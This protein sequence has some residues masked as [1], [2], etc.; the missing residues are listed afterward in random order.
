MVLLKTFGDTRV[1]LQLNDQLRRETELHNERVNKNREIL[2][3]LIDCVLFLGKQE[4]SFRG[5]D[6]SAESRNRGNYVELLSFLAES[7]TDLHYHL[8][9]NK[10]FTGTSGKIQNDLIYA[11]AEVFGEEIKMEIKKAPFVAVMVDETTDVGNVAQ[12]SVV[13]RYVTDTG[14]KERFVRFEDVTSGKRAD[15][16]AALIF[17]FLEEYECSLD[18]VVAQCYDGAAVMASGLNGVQAKVKERAPMALFIHCYAHRLNLVLTQG[19]SKLKE[20][21]LLLYLL[22]VIFI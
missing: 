11:I 21:K 16:I 9:T 18:K 10:V 15:D 13:L 2:K 7:N 8:S 20:C 3:R 19:A 22:N 5:H 4:L 17:R 1:D 14:V 12:L 6:E